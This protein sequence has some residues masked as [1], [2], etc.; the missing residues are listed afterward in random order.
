MIV[1]VVIEL[2]TTNWPAP[3]VWPWV[4][5]AKLVE[6]RRANAEAMGLNPVEVP[7]FFQVNLQN[8]IT[9]WMMISSFKI[10]LNT[11]IVFPQLTSSSFLDKSYIY[12]S[13]CTYLLRV[14]E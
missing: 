9:T 8:A 7:N 11:I 14:F 4:F 1:T 12:E 5:I 10:I 13:L 6:N 2:N 3:N